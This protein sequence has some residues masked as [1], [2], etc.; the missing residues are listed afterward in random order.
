MHA[1]PAYPLG[2]SASGSKMEREQGQIGRPHPENPQA[3]WRLTM[4]Q[5]IN[6]A[7]LYPALG[8]LAR[9]IPAIDQALV[10]V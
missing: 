9:W 6:A 7:L 3:V 10:P 8:L 2:P 4:F 5:P 1:T